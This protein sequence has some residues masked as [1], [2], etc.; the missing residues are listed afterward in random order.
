MGERVVLIEPLQ[1]R[2]VVGVKDANRDKRNRSYSNASPCCSKTGH[3][4]KLRQ[5]MKC[6]EC[7]NDVDRKTCTHKVVKIGKEEHL[8]G[9]DL[10]DGVL[11]QLEQVEEIRIHTIMEK[12]PEGANDRYDSLLYGTPAEKKAKDYKEL[13]ETLRG[14]VA[15]ANGV[16]RNNE[17]QVLVTVG[18]DNVLRFRKLVE[19]SQRYGFDEDAVASA[20]ATPVPEQVIDIQRKILDKKKV[21]EFD[22][23]Q[24]KDSRAAMEEQI[25]E[26]IVVNG[27]VPEVK[28]VLVQAQE[29]NEVERLKALLGE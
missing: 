20:M 2:Y 23:K 12:E 3:P 14:R 11:D 17:F 15:V 21:E 10:L 22:V 24:F 16:F 28:P 19:E 5:E 9:A 4:V 13:V 29:E 6:A 18:D 7:G 25:I 26:D 8:I 27:K 1:K